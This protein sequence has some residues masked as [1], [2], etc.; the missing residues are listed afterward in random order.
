MKRGSRSSPPARLPQ[1]KAFSIEGEF[2]D[3]GAGWVTITELLGDVYKIHQA[4]T[5]D[6]GGIFW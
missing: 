4:L 6:T 2:A 1:I 3:N 5:D